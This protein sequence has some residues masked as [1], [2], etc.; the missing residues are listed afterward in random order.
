MRRR[1]LAG[2]ARNHLDTAL[3]PCWVCGGRRAAAGVATRTVPA[4]AAVLCWLQL[5]AGIGCE[6]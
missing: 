2:A 1:T 5:A 6:G 4:T 3:G